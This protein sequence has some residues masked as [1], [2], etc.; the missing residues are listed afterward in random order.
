M[1][2]IVCD[3][4]L[5]DR[6]VWR[7]CMSGRVR[8]VFVCVVFVC[9]VFVCLVFVCLVFVCVVFVCVVFVCVCRTLY[10]AREMFV[11]KIGYLQVIHVYV[12][13]CMHAFMRMYLSGLYGWMWI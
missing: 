11:G 7:V 10:R 2:T 8:N 6:H 13:M 3:C 12:N 9:L 1:C 4:V 5:F